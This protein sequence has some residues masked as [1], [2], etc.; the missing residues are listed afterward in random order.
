MMGTDTYLLPVADIESAESSKKGRMN[1]KMSK[2]SPHKR[3]RDAREGGVK[4]E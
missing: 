3:I 1:T 2:H 4:V